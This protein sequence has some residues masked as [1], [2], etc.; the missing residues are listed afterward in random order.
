MAND[1]DFETVTLVDRVRVLAGV[2]RSEAASAANKYREGIQR[3]MAGK[4]N[5]ELL[6]ASTVGTAR[7]INSSRAL[8]RRSSALYTDGRPLSGK[9]MAANVVM[10]VLASAAL[11][12]QTTELRHRVSEGQSLLEIKPLKEVEVSYI[13]THTGDVVF[14]LLKLKRGHAGRNKRQLSTHGKAYEVL[15]AVTS[16]TRIGLHLY[17]AK[18]K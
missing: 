14:N 6:I 7:L 11:H 5:P 10:L 3:S 17:A 1:D 9:G 4:S 13:A 15:M 12:A 8:A 16:T 2:A 18:M